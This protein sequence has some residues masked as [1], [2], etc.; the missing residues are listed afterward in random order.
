MSLVIA[1]P[2][3]KDRLSSGPSTSSTALSTEKATVVETE[4]QTPRADSPPLTC[5]SDDRRFWFQRTKDY[6]PNAI[7]T[8]PSVFDD[9]ELAEEY[10][11]RADWEN[12][13]RFDPSA[14]WTWAEELVG[15]PSLACKQR[16]VLIVP[17]R[18]S[19]GNLICASWCWH[20]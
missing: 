6:N 14:R 1:R 13:H 4:R 3:K 18:K 2:Q 9:P 5:A 15:T 16:T 20:A 8:Q 11:P 7:A 10:R 19:S 12:I 17:R